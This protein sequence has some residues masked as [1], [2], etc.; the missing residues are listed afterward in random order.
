MEV[1]RGIGRF[2][3]TVAWMIVLLGSSIVVSAKED[4]ELQENREQVRD[5]LILPYADRFSHYLQRNASEEYMVLLDSLYEVAKETH[6][7][8]LL[9]YC[10]LWRNTE[11]RRRGE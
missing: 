4:N 6:N 7:G 11:L 1:R 2:W 3:A 9:T 8:I 10:H 5:S